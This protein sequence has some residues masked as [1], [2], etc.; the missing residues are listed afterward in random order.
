MKNAHNIKHYMDPTV[1]RHFRCESLWVLNAE[2][3]ISREMIVVHSMHHSDYPCPMNLQL[4]RVLDASVAD[5]GGVPSGFTWT[6]LSTV[7]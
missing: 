3:Y 6:W 5:S 4:E 1:C 7:E 2:A